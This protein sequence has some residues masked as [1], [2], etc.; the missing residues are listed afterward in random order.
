MIEVIAFV[1]FGIALAA[2][3][4]GRKT[5]ERLDG[6][7]AALKEELKRIADREP[8]VSAAGDAAGETAAA[9]VARDAQ[10]DEGTDAGREHKHRAGPG[11][12]Y[13]HKS[14]VRPRESG[15]PGRSVHD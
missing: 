4:N 3:L 5:T 1:A 12:F 8:R 2:L 15:D 11:F 9:V 13:E 6:E 10:A 7:I 14:S